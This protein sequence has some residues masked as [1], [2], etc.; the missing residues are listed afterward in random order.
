M[1]IRDSKAERGAYI[2]QLVEKQEA[3]LKKL[4]EDKAELARIRR[5][6]IQRKRAELIEEWVNGLRESAKVK[7][8][9]PERGAI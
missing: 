1:C 9:L 2:I 6:L 4:K 8:N 3:D 5:S 7:V